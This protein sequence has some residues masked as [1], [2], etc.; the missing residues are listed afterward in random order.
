MI[1]GDAAGGGGA[2]PAAAT[3]PGR[4]RTVPHIQGKDGSELYYLTK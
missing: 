2:E 1:A 3:Q 4:A